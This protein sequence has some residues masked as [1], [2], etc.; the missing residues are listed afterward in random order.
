[1]WKATLNFNIGQ[2]QSFIIPAS[3][4]HFM[5]LWTHSGMGSTVI[6][7]FSSVFA[8]QYWTLTDFLAKIL[9][10]D[11]LQFLHNTQFYFTLSSPLLVSPLKGLFLQFSVVAQLVAW[12]PMVL[13]TRVPFPSRLSVIYFSS[14]F[15]FIYIIF[16]FTHIWQWQKNSWFLMLCF[17]RIFSVKYRWCLSFWSS[18]F[19]VHCIIIYVLTYNLPLLFP[20]LGVVQNKVEF[21]SLAHTCTHKHF[22]WTRH[23]ERTNQTYNPPGKHVKARGQGDDTFWKGVV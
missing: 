17:L 23:H 2:L 21:S 13:V 22:R 14:F 15:K 10:V 20:V 12:I 4:I 5:Q 16:S 3:Y 8:A 18:K 19:A 11:T 6:I 9:G 7:W 1:M